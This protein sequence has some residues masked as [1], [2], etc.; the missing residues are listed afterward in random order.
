MAV[1][2]TWTARATIGGP[3]WVRRT[4]SKAAWFQATT[5][6]PLMAASFA[7]RRDRVPYSAGLPECRG[8]QTPFAAHCRHRR[9]VQDVDPAPCDR[10][11]LPP[12]GLAAGAGAWWSFCWPFHPGPRGPTRAHS[13]DHVP[14][15]TC[16]DG[17]E[18]DPLHGGE[19]THNPPVAGSGHRPGSD[20]TSL[21][22]R[23]TASGPGCCP[24]AAQPAALARHRP[25]GSL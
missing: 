10:R 21:Q 19:A 2:R 18:R 15:L 1:C 4:A 9:A 13:L 12:A 20:P 7:R 17:T 8:V 3:S 6:V 22:P 11:S 24:F 23:L 25:G 16:E 5:A 14:D